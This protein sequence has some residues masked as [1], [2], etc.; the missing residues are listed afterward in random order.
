MDTELSNR[1]LLEA[2]LRDAIKNNRLQ[3]LYQPIVK[4]GE[5]VIG[6][7]A[8]GRWN[9]PLRGEIPPTEFI[10]VAERRKLI[11]GAWVLRRACLNGGK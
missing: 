1:K 4:S 5:E 7:E 9:H 11:I 2:D 6:V 10:A 8:L 3:L